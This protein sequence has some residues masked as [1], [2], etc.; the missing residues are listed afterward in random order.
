MAYE[1]FVFVCQKDIP[2]P[3]TISA[4]ILDVKKEI[5]FPW[6]TEFEM[7]HDYWFGLQGKPAIT[8]DT[9]VIIEQFLLY[10]DYWMIMPVSILSHFCKFDQFRI[11]EIEQTITPRTTYI[12]RNTKMVNRYHDEI[13]EII[14]DVVNGLD[15]FTPIK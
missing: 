14:Q 15:G 7:W 9:I 11:C 2:Y 10:N 3:D 4:E 13:M 5:Y 6:T 12:A 8:V 1:K